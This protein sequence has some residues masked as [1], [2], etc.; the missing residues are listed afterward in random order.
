MLD[1]PITEMR[2]QMKKLA[3]F[4]DVAFNGEGDGPRQVGFALLIY[5]FGDDLKGTGRVNYIGNGRRD[6]VLVALKELLAS[7]ETEDR[8]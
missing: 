5:K 1:D 2:G 7:W 3:K 6:D 8:K 4:L